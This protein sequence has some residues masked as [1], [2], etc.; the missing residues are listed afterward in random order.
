[1]ADHERDPKVSSRYAELGCEEPS[2]ALDAA[3]L[4]AARRAAETRPAPLVAPTGRRRWYFPM[5]AAAVIVLAVAVTMQVEREQPDQEA[6]LPPPASPPP[7]SPTL[8]RK[9]EQARTQTLARAAPDAKRADTPVAKTKPRPE[10][11]AVHQEPAPPS[12]E[13]QAAAQPA[14]RVAEAARD[15]I[16]ENKVQGA[17]APAARGPMRDE[18]RNRAFAAK[19]ESPDEW[20]ERIARLRD[21]RRDEEADRAFE[22]FKRRYPDY[23]IS[24]AMLE[25]LAKRH[26]APDK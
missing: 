22:D 24:K 15:A 10:P 26:A 25:R 4:A 6:A 23:R 2:P 13:P 21:E 7:A 18:A 14:P 9:Q 17:P 16:Q 11:E 20:L 5:A 8:E 1:M 3:I 12:A 19:I